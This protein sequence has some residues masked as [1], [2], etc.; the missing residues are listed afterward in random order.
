MV[1]MKSLNRTMVS[2]HGDSMLL[3]AFLLLFLTSA[4]QAK[5]WTAEDVPIAYLQDR[6]QYLTDPDELV[7]DEARDSANYWLGRIEKETGVQPLFIVASAVRNGDAFRMAE[8]VGNKYG[9]GTKKERSGLVVVIAVEDHQYFIAPGKGVEGVLTDVECGRIGRSC[10]RD[11]MRN[12]DLDAAVVSTTKALYYKLKGN[13]AQFEHVVQTGEG[14]DDDIPTWEIF[15][16]ILLI[17][18]PLLGYAWWKSRHGGMG[19]GRGGRNHR[20]DG[21]M[22]LFIFFGGGGGS[23]VSDIDTGGSF[24]GGSFGGGGAGGGW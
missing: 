15:L 24:G 13:N 18:G 23:D 2:R 8:D 5:V 11:N 19:G 20:G 12:D 16:L 3:L 4:V 1:L 10:I 22:P 9:V 17:F 14:A 6:T 21:G 7:S